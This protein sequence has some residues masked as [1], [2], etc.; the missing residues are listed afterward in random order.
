[1]RGRGVW[2]KLNSL[3]ARGESCGRSSP[4]RYTLRF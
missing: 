3:A 1:M 2:P 4:A